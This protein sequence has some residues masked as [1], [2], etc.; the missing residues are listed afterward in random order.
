MWTALRRHII[1]I[2]VASLAVPSM[3]AQFPGTQVQRPI[4]VGAMPGAV[5]YKVEAPR[6]VQPMQIGDYEDRSVATLPI[7]SPIFQWMPPVIAGVAGAVTYTYDIKIVQ[8][9]PEQSLDQAIDHNP[10]VYQTKGLSVPQC[11]LPANI[12]RGLDPEALYVAQVVTYARS[13]DAVDIANGGRGPLMPF[14]VQVAED[15][16]SQ[17]NN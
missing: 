12:A 10:V 7:L 9:M 14:R 13:T 16:N 8:V 2:A 17:T 4:G 6:W 1:Y 3:F 11:L 5:R 15:T